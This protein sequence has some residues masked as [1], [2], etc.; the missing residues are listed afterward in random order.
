MEFAAGNAEAKARYAKS[1][2][3]YQEAVQEAEFLAERRQQEQQAKRSRTQERS[4]SSSSSTFAHQPNRHRGVVMEKKTVK[5]AGG[6]KLEWCYIEYIEPSSPERGRLCDVHSGRALGGGA[7]G[8]RL[9]CPLLG[10]QLRVTVVLVACQQ[11]SRLL[12]AR[13]ANTVLAL[14]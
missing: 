9:H 3:E 12:A 1:N 2:A 14:L 11:S 13:L 8:D 7:G 4:S 6:S 5:G 10:V